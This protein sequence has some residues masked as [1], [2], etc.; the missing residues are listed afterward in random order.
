MLIFLTTLLAALRAIFRSRTALELENLAL[1]YQIGVLQRST[2]KRPKLTAGDRMLW[3]FLS[4][5]WRDWRSALAMVQPET[6]V[7]WHRTGFR[8]L[9]MLRPPGAHQR[10]ADDL[11]GGFDVWIPQLG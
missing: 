2:T 11:G 5:V 10:F 7:A 6:V 9:Q 3:V 8:L 1:R 4:R